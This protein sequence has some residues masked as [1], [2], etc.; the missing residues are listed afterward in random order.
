MA[1]ACP[2]VCCVFP[3]NKDLRE[4]D[5]WTVFEHWHKHLLQHS[6]NKI[7]C[8]QPCRC[9]SKNTYADHF[10]LEMD[11]ITQFVLVVLLEGR[12]R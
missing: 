3:P 4:T 5:I 7:V 12:S 6:S 1:H 9:S 10:M 8:V 2:A 11:I